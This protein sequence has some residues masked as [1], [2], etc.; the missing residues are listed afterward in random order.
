MMNYSVSERRIRNN[1][2]R[3]RR[4]LKHHILMFITTVLLISCFS[5]CFFSFKA[6]AQSGSEEIAYKYYKS[7]T[8]ENGDTIWDYAE[9][10]A[11]SEYYDSYDC[12]IKEVIRINSLSDDSIQSGQYIIIPYYSYEFVG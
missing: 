9:K 8:V 4:Q 1:R 6:K 5:V 11:D 10:Y 2:I 3:R 12:Y 7:I